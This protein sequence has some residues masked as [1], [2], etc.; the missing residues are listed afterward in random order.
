MKEYIIDGIPYI[1]KEQFYKMAHVRK[2]TALRLIQEGL[3]PAVD[4]GKQTNRYLIRLSDAE[5]Y[6][7]DRIVHPE[8]Y[9]SQKK[10]CIQTYP[11]KFNRGFARDLSLCAA[12]L[13]A[14]E[15]ALLTVAQVHGLLGYSEGVIRRWYQES[16]LQVVRVVNRLY[17]PKKS[18]LKFLK[19]KTFCFITQ[20]SAKHIELIRRTEYEGQSYNSNH[21]F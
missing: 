15:P 17:I 9:S 7:Q 6:L 21:E 11:G 4:T 10:A 1:S 12:N 20:K 18:L 8:K 14:D 5:F 19:T 13:W 16:G 2:A 3:V